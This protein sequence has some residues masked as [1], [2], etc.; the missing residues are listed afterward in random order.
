MMEILGLCLIFIYILVIGYIGVK[1]FEKSFFMQDKTSEK[2]VI[3][4]ENT[5]WVPCF[6][7][8][9]DEFD[10]KGIKYECIY[11]N[12]T[13]IDELLNTNKIDLA[14]MFNKQDALQTHINLPEKIKT[15]N[16]TIKTDSEV[17]DCYLTFSPYIS[18]SLKLWITSY[19][20]NQ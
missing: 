8:L 1:G 9:F 17:D 16:I 6:H 4:F 7:F 18:M 20:Q 10:R 14:F 3:A 19:I 11:A 15:N 5:I 2:V 13:K 12:K